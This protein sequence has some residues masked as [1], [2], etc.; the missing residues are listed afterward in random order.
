M[1]KVFKGPWIHWCAFIA[2]LVI[3]WAAGS[4]A[5][6]VRQFSMFIFLLFGLSLALVLLIDLSDRR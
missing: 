5:L 1:S 2:V 6:H 3:L 4:N